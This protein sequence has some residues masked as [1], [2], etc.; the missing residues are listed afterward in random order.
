MPL[1][2]VH[3]RINDSA[4]GQPTPVRLRVT[5]SAGNYYAPF[6]HAAEFPT[7]RGEAVGGD[8]VVDGKRWAYIDGACEIAVPPGELIVEAT[9]GPE[10][11]ALRETLTLPPGKMALRFAV[12]RVTDLRSQGWYSGDTRAHFISPHAA[13]LEAAAEDLAIVHL[14][15]G[16]TPML[17]ADG[18]SYITYPG[19]EAFSGRASILERNGHHVVVGTHNRHP[20]L[21]EVALLHSHRVVYPLNFGGADATDDW[22]LGD[23][24][25]QCHRKGGLVVWTNAATAPVGHAAE[26]VAHAILGHV[27]AI[28]F[29]P[30]RPEALQLW[31][32]LLNVGCRLSLVGASAKLSNE[33]VLG[34]H[35]TYARIAEG[36]PFDLSAWIESVRAGRTVMSAGALL[37]FTAD[38]V[39]PGATLERQAEATIQLF[40]KASGNFELETVETIWNGRPVDLKFELDT[41]GWLAARVWSAGRRRLAAHTAPIWVQVAGVPQ[42]RHAGALAALRRHLEAGR[43][44]VEREG[45]FEQAKSRAKLLQVFGEALAKLPNDVA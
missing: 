44:W 31:Y 27:D 10:Y 35:R 37:D 20:V 43:D 26:A 24:C 34:A 18:Q 3:I 25:D 22:S 41:T 13:L 7:G 2:I 17:A 42:R 6:G 1:Q 21:G 11:S 29:S 8:V 45:R 12:Q 9:K 40:A 33:T 15:V 16:A 28:E 19:L 39:L 32:Q 14:L 4:T 23:W 30:G 38:E 36:N 5:D